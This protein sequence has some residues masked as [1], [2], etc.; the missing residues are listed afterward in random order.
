[1]ISDRMRTNWAG[2]LLLAGAV[3]I[4]M[5]GPAPAQDGARSFTAGSCLSNVFTNSSVSPIY[6]M[7]CDIAH[8]PPPPGCRGNVTACVGGPNPVYWAARCPVRQETALDGPWQYS[9]DYTFAELFPVAPLGGED[10]ECLKYK[11]YIGYFDQTGTFSPHYPSISNG[12]IC[13]PGGNINGTAYAEL[14]IPPNNYFGAKFYVRT[15][16][17]KNTSDGLLT[18]CDESVSENLGDLGLPICVDLH[19]NSSFYVNSTTSDPPYP[20]CRGE[21]IPTLTQWG[22]MLMS[23]AI[24]V[25]GVW[26]VRRR[27]GRSA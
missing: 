20:I 11:L 24:A 25:C 2:V 23:L 6:T 1:M 13:Y 7:Y 14:T 27:V 19:M 17:Y 4:L 16:C 22:M 12:T 18:E 8:V 3:M 21:V 5:A 15:P 26:V 10:T 9:L